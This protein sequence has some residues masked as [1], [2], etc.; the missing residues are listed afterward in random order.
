MT[1]ETLECFAAIARGS[2]FM[3]VAEDFN[4]SQ[5]ALSKIIKKAEDEIGVKLFDRSG[6][7]VHLTDAGKQMLE[8]YE[9]ME[10]YYN[11]MKLHMRQLSSGYRITV[12]LGMPA[13]LMH[14]ENHLNRF[15]EEHPEIL[16]DV[17]VPNYERVKYAATAA[18]AEDV[19][20]VIMHKTVQ[21]HGNSYVTLVPADPLY[22]FMPKNHPL[23]SKETVTLE[24]IC[25]EIIIVNNWGMEKLW[26]LSRDYQILFP[27]AREIDSMR[28]EDLL[29]NVITGRGITLMH[30]SD[31]TNINTARVAMCPIAGIHRMP[32]IM[33]TRSDSPVK[34]SVETL[35]KYLQKEIRRELA[36]RDK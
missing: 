30:Q 23:A 12:V 26:G 10:P 21:Y 7:S 31:V 22:V 32:I 6:R 35:K 27:N 5:S 28:R 4:L 18:R 36:A 11:A 34:E 33:I 3:N 24:D 20:V 8:D 15:Q 1:F 29:W 16:L 13:K 25:K 19:D 2:T 17:V 14:F 9:R